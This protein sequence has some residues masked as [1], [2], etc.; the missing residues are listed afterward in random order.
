M[1]PFCA[2]R[3]KD[4]ARTP[5]QILYSG[6][7]GHLETEIGPYGTAGPLI[8]HEAIYVP[9]VGKIFGVYQA[10]NLRPSVWT[11]NPVTNVA[12]TPYNLGGSGL[13]NDSHGCPEMTI[14]GDGYLYV[15]WGCHGSYIYWRKS[16]NPYD[17][18][19]WGTQQQ[20]TTYAT[21]PSVF[22]LG[23]TWY[24]FHR[25]LLSY[26]LNWQYHSSANLSSWSAATE[27]ILPK[28][29]DRPY[30]I[31]RQNPSTQRLHFLWSL[32]NS[33]NL[34]N[35]NVYY[36]YTDDMAT[37]HKA[38]GTT[39][40]LPVTTD[41][42]ECL[43]VDGFTRTQ[44]SDIAFDSSNRPCVITNVNLNWKL[45]RWNGSAWITT[46]ISP[47]EPNNDM[48]CGAILTI[49]ANNNLTAVLDYCSA[50]GTWAEFVDKRIYRSTDLGANWTYVGTYGKRLIRSGEH[51]VFGGESTGFSV[52]SSG[53]ENSVTDIILI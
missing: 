39:Y 23:T 2:S 43:V 32:W 18:T 9:S 38:D 36:A 52:Y 25:G 20:I 45:I 24:L 10:T 22:K 49:D 13:T 42:A 7:T 33:G 5:Y 19:A 47:G 40:T 31:I 4:E 53:S 30:V 37:W 16:T 14:D 34:T 29:L 27:F 1:Y 46:T 35:R 15:Y 21:Y 6:V 12:S 17:I 51:H 44:Y 11:Y 50:E 8:P 3:H 48:F 26:P 28:D 41:Q